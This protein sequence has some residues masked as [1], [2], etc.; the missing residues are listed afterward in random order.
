MRVTFIRAVILVVA[1]TLTSAAIIPRNP[2]H[3]GTGD[4]A[5]S[6]RGGKGKSRVHPRDL[7]LAPDNADIPQ[8]RVVENHPPPRRHARDFSRR[9][10]EVV[11][12][13]DDEL[14][15]FEPETP[16]HRRRHARDFTGEAVEP[17]AHRNL[18]PAR[19]THPRQFRAY[20]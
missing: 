11:E 15:E 7:L 3:G 13:R 4:G 10:I 17:D 12:V 6:M 14:D 8:R 9:D 5:S 18:P 2:S 19:R 20:D 16:K 1:A